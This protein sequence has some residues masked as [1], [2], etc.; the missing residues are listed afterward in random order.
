MKKARRF[1]SAVLTVLFLFPAISASAASSGKEVVIGGMPFG[2]TMYTSGV[3][4]ISVDDNGSP[5]KEAG[6]REN[7]I[8]TKAN[9][10]E[11]STNEELKEIIEK[12]AGADIELSLTRGKS[13]I[14]LRITPEQNGDGEYTVGMWIRDSAAGLGTVTYFDEGSY[15]FGALGHGICDRD[16]G[17]L[18]PRVMVFR[19]LLA[20]LC[21]N[22]TR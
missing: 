7:D 4:V 12:S 22:G 6:V 13:P 21:E 19:V 8:I 16:T 18:L 2:L 17:I 9:G 3:I 14:S 5:A 15:S 10:E 11:I 20:L 1:M